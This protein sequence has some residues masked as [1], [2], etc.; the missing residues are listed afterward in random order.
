MVRPMPIRLTQPLLGLTSVSQFVTLHASPI[1][2][3]PPR[4]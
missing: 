2:I 4:C 3:A 1:L